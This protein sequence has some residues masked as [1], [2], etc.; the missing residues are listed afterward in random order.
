MDAHTLYLIRSRIFEY[1]KGLKGKLPQLGFLFLTY[2]LTARVGRLVSESSNQGPALIWP[3][4]GIS[5]AFLYLGG[6]GLWP[7]VALGSLVNNL[8]NG[9]SIGTSIVI[10]TANTI[11]ALFG[12]SV[13]KWLSFD[14][15][16]DRLWDITILFLTAIVATTVAPTFGQAGIYALNGFQSG[17]ISVGWVAWWLGGVLSV[18]I[19]TPLV[20][21]WAGPIKLPNRKKALELSIAYVVLLLVGYVIFWTGLNAIAAIPLIYLI[22]LPLFWISLRFQPKYV[23]MAM[24]LM[25]FVAVTGII[26]GQ[27][28]TSKEQI[29]QQLMQIETLTLMLCIIFY[30]ISSITAERKNAENNLKDYVNQLERAVETIRQHALH[31]I[32]TGLPNRKAMEERFGVTKSIAIRHGHK[33]AMLFLDLDQFKNINDT[34]GHSIGDLVLKEVA[35]RLQ[36]SIRQVD[37]VARLGGDEFIIILSEIHD[38]AD[39]ENVAQ[40]VLEAFTDSIKVQEHEIQTSTSIGIAVYPDAGQDINEL[41][42]SADI[43]L[44][45]AKDK[46]RNQYQFY[47]LD[48]KNRLHAKLSLEHDLRHAIEKQQLRLVYQ[49]HVD[50]RTNQILGVEALIRW[51]HPVL[52]LLSPKDF[53]PLAEETGLINPIGLWVLNRACKQIRQWKKFGFTVPVS[54]NLSAKQFFPN[55]LVESITQALQKYDLRPGELDLEITETVAMQTLYASDQLEELVKMGVSISMDD[56]GT[57]YSSLGYI[58]TLFLNRLKIDQAFVKNV[59]TDP[60]D[61]TIIRTIISMGHTLGLKI[62]AEGI[63]TQEQRTLLSSMGCDSGQGY[64]FCKPM[65]GTSIVQLFEKNA[66]KV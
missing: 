51:Q 4:A 20:V 21:S 8:L 62:C 26:F 30:I 33:V 23:S 12:A 28:L 15:K 13:L 50:L 16:L 3:P 29:G 63:E 2:V 7:A 56:F 14:N 59:I 48:M 41:L 54:I 47:D 36:E 10:A 35:S 43:A 52:G 65:D 38:I 9:T 45:R 32:L 37:T 34:L 24:F 22:L 44:Y 53:I 40:K 25:N 5:I 42:R 57:G 58:K 55:N 64:L 60:H 31:D 18:A 61:E 46:G 27:E 19:L 17:T 39:I 66:V 49:P 1:F 6:Y 11:Q